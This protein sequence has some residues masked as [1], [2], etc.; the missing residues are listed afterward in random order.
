MRKFSIEENLKAKLEKL[1]KKDTV[2]YYALMRK[3]DEIL[4]S[5]EINHYKNLRRPLQHLK[6]VHR[7]GA[8]Y[9]ALRA[10]MN[11]RH[12]H[13]NFSNEPYRPLRERWLFEKSDIIGPFVLTFKYVEAEDNVIFYDFDHH[14]RIYL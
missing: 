8:G 5:N 1:F 2:T 3:M 11:A 9:T 10:G 13:E 7:D 6:R 4:N 12:R 14:D